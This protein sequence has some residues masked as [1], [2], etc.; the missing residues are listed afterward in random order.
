MGEDIL[1]LME[2][3]LKTFSKGQRRIA[4][5]VIESYDKAAYDSQ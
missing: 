3:M 1:S 2:S 4:T 5:F